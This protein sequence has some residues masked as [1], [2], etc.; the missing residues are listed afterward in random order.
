MQTEEEMEDITRKCVITMFL[1][2]WSI[3]CINVPG[4]KESRTQR[5]AEIV[6][7]RPGVLVPRINFG[8]CL[9]PVAISSPVCGRLQRVKL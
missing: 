2:P 4:L 7:G 3:L 1:R 6:P 8:A 9:R 5:L